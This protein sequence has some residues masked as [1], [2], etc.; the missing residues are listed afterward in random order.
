MFFF[1]FES[2]TCI[3][4]A[5]DKQNVKKSWCTHFT[6]RWGKMSIEDFLFFEQPVLKRRNRRHDHDTFSERGMTCHDM[7]T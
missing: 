6:P 4:E 7:S 1:K 3:A 5:L 2:H